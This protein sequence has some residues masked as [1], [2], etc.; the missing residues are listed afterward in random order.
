MKL[1]EMVNRISSLGRRK[2]D[3]MMVKAAI[4][5]YGAIVLNRYDYNKDIDGLQSSIN[6][7]V[8]MFAKSGV[9]KSYILKQI[10]KLCS[11]ENYSEQM[12]VMYEYFIDMLPDT[13]KDPEVIRFIPQSPTLGIDGTREGLFYHATSVLECNFGSLNIYSE[14]FLDSISSS[15]ELI[16]KL[17][18]LYDGEYKAKVIKGQKDDQRLKDVKG[19][20]VNFI[21]AG[22]KD[23]ATKDERDQLSKI[24]KSGLFRRSLVV[25][26]CMEPE[27]SDKD[28]EDTTIIGDWFQQLDSIHKEDYKERVSRYGSTGSTN[29]TIKIDNDA[30][31]YIEELDSMLLKRAK[32]DPFNV[33]YGFDTGALN[34]IVNIAYIIAF[35]EQANSVTIEHLE[36]AYDF[37]IE[38]RK[39]VEQ[40]FTEVKA[41]DEIYNILKK[42]SNLTHSELIELSGCDCIPKAKNQFKDTMLLVKEL[43]YRDGKELSNGR[44]IVTRYSIRELENTN[45][46]KLIFS[47][48]T[49]N[50]REKAIAFEPAVLPWEDIEKLCKHETIES[51]TC[52]H[53]E[54]STKTEPYGHR[55]KD[56]FIQGQ[57]V[58]TFDI[59]N[60]MTIR[61]AQA[62]LEPFTYALYT[63][64]SHNSEKSEYGNRFRIVIPTKNMFYV[65]DEQHKQLIENTENMI[66]LTSNDSQTR[67]VS[68]LFFTNPNAEVFYTNDGDLLDISGCMPDTN[69]NDV[70]MVQL[71]KV[72]EYKE[73]EQDVDETTK[74]LNGFLRYCVSTVNPNDNLKDTIFRLR[75]FVYDLTGD[76]ALT[77]DYMWRFQSIKGFPERFIHEQ[78]KRI[79]Q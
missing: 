26:S 6:M 69:K 35:I 33:F 14:E 25:D 56:N 67:N 15:N 57:N 34:M 22:S 71:E 7:F 63:T 32:D 40:T 54:P 49:D 60:G 27:K 36:Y 74:R 1:D 2:N 19:I 41:H 5:Y 50:K 47:L 79:G 66:G 31:Q 43:A 13:E 73:Q 48:S 55:K 38:T 3:P 18:E 78:L 29:K 37:F 46:K 17:K 45:L 68:R 52:C 61:E 9:G 30:R 72:N 21:G 44:G 59:D 62:L 11:L 23:G 12:E 4:L 77:E 76:I 16:K 8:L 28:E 10:E 64:K 42:K 53:Y 51:F 39:T 58:I 65:T 75:K 20:V 24:A 70:V